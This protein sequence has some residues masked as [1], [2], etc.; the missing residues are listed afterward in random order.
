MTVTSA[1]TPGSS[2]P[3]FSGNLKTL[4]GVQ[5]D[6]LD[7]LLDG[8]AEMQVLRHHPGKQLTVRRLRRLR[9][10]IGRDQIGDPTLAER[11][12]GVFPEMVRRAGLPFRQDA[13]VLELQNLRQHFGGRCRQ[14]RLASSASGW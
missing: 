14:T 3:S 13:A 10:D 9:T 5:R 11:L 4:V 2:V 6:A 1:A 8:E 12:L 7:D